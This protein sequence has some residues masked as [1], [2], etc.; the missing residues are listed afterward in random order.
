MKAWQRTFCRGPVPGLSIRG[1]CTPGNSRLGAVSCAHACTNRWRTCAGVAPQA[2]RANGRQA[3]LAPVQEDSARAR[4]LHPGQFAPLGPGPQWGPSR[5]D[6][7]GRRD[8]RF[9]RAHRTTSARARGLHPGQFALWAARFARAHRATS[10]RARRWLP[11]RQTCRMAAQDNS[12]GL[13]PG[14]FAPMGGKLRLRLCKRIAHV[15]GGGIFRAKYG[16]EPGRQFQGHGA[17]GGKKQ[18]EKRPWQ[19]PLAFSL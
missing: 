10:A 8:A 2:I 5:T 15:R 14:Q 3:T 11:P 9:A 18:K 6:R 7:A 4:G 12:R 16:S 13:H 17:T 1:G 19:T